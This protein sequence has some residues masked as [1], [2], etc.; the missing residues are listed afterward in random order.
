MP[1]NDEGEKKPELEWEGGAFRPRFGSDFC[2][3]REGRKEG[4]LRKL[5]RM[6]YST[7]KG[8]PRLMRGPEQRFLISGDLLEAEMPQF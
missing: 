3:R 1:V 5:L 8:L 7:E 6:Q 2:K 4:G